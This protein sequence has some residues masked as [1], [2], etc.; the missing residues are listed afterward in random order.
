MGESEQ[1]STVGIVVVHYRSKLD[2]V[3]F[4]RRLSAAPM[5]EGASRRV[6]VVDNGGE[7]NDSTIRGGDEEVRLVRPDRN[8]G[9]LNGANF[10]IEGFLTQHEEHPEWWIVTNPDVRVNP[11]FFQTLLG[12]S[13]PKTI[14]LLSPDVREERAWPRNP[15]HQQRPTA[16][17]IRS[18]FILFSIIP[19]ASLYVQAAQWKRA[20][21][22]P[23]SVPGGGERIYATHGSLMIFHRRFFERGGTLEYEGFLYGEEIHVAEQARQMD[24]EIRWAPSLRAFHRGRTDVDLVSMA[25][26]FQ[27]WKESYEFLYRSYFR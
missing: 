4:L 14:G 2:T 23:P 8:L 18:R 12:R 19:L 13:W 20:I 17:W 16:L 10:G 24:L 7:L 22:Q 6:L 5:P 11:T 25:E 3:R 1:Q 26:R 21:A 9:Y 27:W 15:F